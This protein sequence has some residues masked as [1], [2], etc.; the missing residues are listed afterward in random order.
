MIGDRAYH[1]KF[2]CWTACW[3]YFQDHTHQAV[4]WTTNQHDPKN[5][6]QTL[7]SDDFSIKVHWRTFLFWWN[8]M[9][10]SLSRHLF[11]DS[12]SCCVKNTRC[13]RDMNFSEC[14]GNPIDIFSLFMTANRIQEDENLFMTLLAQ[15]RVTCDSNRKIRDSG[16]WH[17]DFANT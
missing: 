15:N 12:C 11:T 10:T 17:R 5:Q 9:Q 14:C 2:S 4:L 16:I 8:S 7:R 1:E 6:S 13:G 3:C